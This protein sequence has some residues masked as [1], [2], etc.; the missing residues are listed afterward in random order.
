MSGGCVVGAGRG[1]Y[2][3]AMSFADSF[4]HTHAV[5]TKP[6]WQHFGGQ[7]AVIRDGQT[8][9]DAAFGTLGPDDESPMTAEHRLCWRSAGKPWT[10]VALLQLRDEGRLSLD[11]GV[12]V[13]L[14]DFA[15][16]GVTLR[17]LLT[18]T[19]GLKF[20]HVTWPIGGRDELLAK[21]M[22]ARLAGGVSPG[23]GSAYD[24]AGAWFL[25]GEVI[26]RV[27]GRPIEEAVAERVFGPAGVSAFLSADYAAVADTLAPQ[28]ATERSGSTPLP[29]H[30][31]EALAFASPGSSSRGR[32]SDLATLYDQLLRSL[33][34]EG[35]LLSATTAA[36]MTSRH[37]E[38]RK[39]LTFGAVTDVG[40]GVLINP[41]RYGQPNVPYSFGP[42]ASDNTFGHGGAQCA[43]GFADPAAGV[44]AAW[45]VNGLPGEPRHNSRNQAVNAAI[46]EDLGLV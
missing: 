23:E 15:V 43:M 34:G 21:L 19:S 38:G 1:T 10:A 29:L 18:H 17:H 37:R 7:V 39:D 24:P 44:A 9:L 36:E 27:D 32:A 3:S 35:G 25:L 8:V 45:V 30:T 26:A 12:K 22:N 31:P 41:N 2:R 42:H 13:Y 11:D 4:P 33:R 5:L 14:P 40:L 28:F 20:P 6:T 46:Y 16:G